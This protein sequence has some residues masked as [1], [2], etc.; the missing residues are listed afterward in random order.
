MKTIHDRMPVILTA[1]AYDRWLDPDAKPE[2]PQGL[3][4]P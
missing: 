4:C 1:S 3:L 2:T